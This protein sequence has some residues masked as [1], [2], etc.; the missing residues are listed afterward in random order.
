[1][2]RAIART[3]TAAASPHTRT[4]SGLGYDEVMGTE[5]S[6]FGSDLEVADQIGSHSPA[7]SP[8]SALRPASCV[9]RGQGAAYQHSREMVVAQ[10][11]G[12]RA[13]PRPEKDCGSASSS[14]AAAAARLLR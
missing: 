13:G 6:A 4:R 7:T 5:R 12:A 8:R 3:M 14:A 2:T 10:F 9:G 11:D 1:M